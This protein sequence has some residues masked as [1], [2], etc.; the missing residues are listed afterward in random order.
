MFVLSR[1]SGTGYEMLDSKGRA[2][3]RTQPSASR[4]SE[5][6]VEDCKGSK[7]TVL[8]AQTFSWQ[9]NSYSWKAKAGLSLSESAT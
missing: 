8:D 9:G 7:L 6:V 4:E 1:A 3:L 5:A 2:V